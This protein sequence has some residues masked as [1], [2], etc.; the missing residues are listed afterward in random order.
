MNIISC[1][2]LIM[3]TI[4]PDSTHIFINNYISTLANP[5]SFTKLNNIEPVCRLCIFNISYLV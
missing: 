3:V 2:V 5:R 4:K 1:S